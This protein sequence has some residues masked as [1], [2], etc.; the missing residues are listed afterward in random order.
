MMKK[1]VIILWLLFQNEKREHI[2]KD[3]EE[4]KNEGK[5]PH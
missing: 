2:S 1:L 3:H 4:D 5:R